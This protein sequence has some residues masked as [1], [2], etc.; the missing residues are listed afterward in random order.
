MSGGE[1]SPVPLSLG[2]V[3]AGTV[4]RWD[5]LSLISHCTAIKG[6]YAM[7]RRRA[8][9]LEREGGIRNCKYMR[10]LPPVAVA[11]IGCGVDDENKKELPARMFN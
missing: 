4:N 7:R 6:N 9:L 8:C 10:S 3:A 1:A 5:R 2:G 11:W